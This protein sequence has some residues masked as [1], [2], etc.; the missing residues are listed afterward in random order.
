MVDKI[1]KVLELLEECSED[2]L[3]YMKQLEDEGIVGDGSHE[4]ESDI[5]YDLYTD[6]AF[7]ICLAIKML[8]EALASGTDVTSTVL[9]QQEKEDAID[10]RSG[11]L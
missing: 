8:E 5:F 6:N 9:V 10:V 11:S 4:A 7:K 3:K 1:K 2:E